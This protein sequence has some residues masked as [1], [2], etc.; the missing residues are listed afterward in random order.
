MPGTE[1][2]REKSG[3]RN[4]KVELRKI[5]SSVRWW[6]REGRVRAIEQCLRFKFCGWTWPVQSLG[7][8]PVSSGSSNQHRGFH[9]TQMAAV[10]SLCFKLLTPHLGEVPWPP[11]DF[12]KYQRFKRSSLLSNLGISFI[13][14][15]SPLPWLSSLCS[16]L[17]HP[18]SDVQDATVMGDGRGQMGCLEARRT[19]YELLP[20]LDLLVSQGCHNKWPQIRWLKTTEIYSLIIPE[21][22][23]LKWRCLQCWF[24][25]EALRDNVLCISLLAYGGCQPS[26]VFLGL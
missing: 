24:L 2:K 1:G 14:F 5:N 12:C 9:V 21:S 4:S 19:L 17:T 11:Q 18:W 7:F 13:K 26:L 3:Q 23:S 20:W 8:L 22:K 15:L 6:T 10:T 25:L 16:S